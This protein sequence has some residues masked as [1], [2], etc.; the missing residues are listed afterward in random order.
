MVRKVILLAA[1]AMV[2]VGVPSLISMPEYDSIVT[3][4]SDASMTVEI[5]HDYYMCHSS[6]SNGDW[7]MY[8]NVTIYYDC[9]VGGEYPLGENVWSEMNPSACGD[10]TDNDGDGLIDSQDP[11]CRQ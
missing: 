9:T 2:A 8:Q 6:W 4:Y 10:W 7:S 1:I 5:G 3:Y 11:D